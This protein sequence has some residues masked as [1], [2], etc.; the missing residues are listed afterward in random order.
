MKEI[1]AFFPPKF[2]GG[3]GEW[4]NRVSHSWDQ[5]RRRAGEVFQLSRTLVP[6]PLLT[7]HWHSEGFKI[8]MSR[9]IWLY[10]QL[11]GRR[12]YICRA[13]HCFTSNLTTCHLKDIALVFH[14]VCFAYFWNCGFSL[15]AFQ[16]GNTL[17]APELLKPSPRS[18]HSNV[19]NVKKWHPFQ[20]AMKII[21]G[22]KIRG[23]KPQHTC[24]KCLKVI[25]PFALQSSGIWRETSWGHTFIWL[26]IWF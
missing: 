18:S 25:W 6:S 10:L 16:A 9:N 20:H 7:W 14:F 11:K 21:F 17:K 12:K 22:G 26:N 2:K 19:A 8:K 1:L 23:K 5:N 4:V 24:K 3:Q 15:E 13:K